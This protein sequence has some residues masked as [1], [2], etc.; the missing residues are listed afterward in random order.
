MK[1]LS[2]MQLNEYLDAALGPAP[3]RRVEA[4]LQSCAV[5]R[6]RLGALQLVF[7]GLAGLP[8]AR[9]AHDLSGPVLA[10]LP[11][12][13]PRPLAPVQAAQAGAALGGFVWLAG[14]ATRLLPGLDL[15]FLMF[16]LPRPVL[17]HLQLTLPDIHFSLP[18]VPLNAIPWADFSTFSVALLIASAGAL[19]VVGNAA[20]LRGRTEL[21][22]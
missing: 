15:S 16:S 18:T 3:R 22:S 13:R 17:P 6:K 11:G 12:G 14:Q 1:H 8:E 21:K 2:D 9:L 4:H 19:W 20:L 10:M 7:S 5:C